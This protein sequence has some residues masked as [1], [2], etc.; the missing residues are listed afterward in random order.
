MNRRLRARHVRMWGALAVL[1]PIG[2]AAAIYSRTPIPTVGVSGDAMP[3]DPAAHATFDFLDT[4]IRA[5]LGPAANGSAAIVELTA[6]E[7]PALPDVL[8][9]WT[10]TGAGATT[11]GLRGDE[12]L[13]GSFFGRRTHRFTLPADA[14]S[15]TADSVANGRLLF[16][17]LAHGEV[18]AELNV[19]E[20]GG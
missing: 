20:L 7:D 14:M 9:Y 12:L 2:L 4:R 11:S 13:L 8:V 3:D 17:S 18:V 19:D 15:A 16:Y 5:R 1:L 10:S 6:E